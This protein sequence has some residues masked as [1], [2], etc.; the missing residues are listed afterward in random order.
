M[1]DYG[2]KAQTV[3]T[4]NYSVD[5]GEA[6]EARSY[7]ASQL[8]ALAT[9]VEEQTIAYNILKKLRH[10]EAELG[11]LLSGTLMGHLQMGQTDYLLC[12]LGHWVTDESGA[13]SHYEA[14]GW[15]MVPS[16][17]Y[18]AYD[19]VLTDNELSWDTQNNWFKK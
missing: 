7:T 14:V 11:F 3:F 17:L 18:A 6:V 4:V 10:K 12:E 2:A 8:E 19:A 1:L 16:G 5:G 13:L 9:E 15:V